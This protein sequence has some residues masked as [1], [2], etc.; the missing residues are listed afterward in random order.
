MLCERLVFKESFEPSKNG[1]I[2]KE[3]KK[4]RKKDRVR[5]DSMD[6]NVRVNAI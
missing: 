6:N 5:R 4:E 3:R 2:K 1:L